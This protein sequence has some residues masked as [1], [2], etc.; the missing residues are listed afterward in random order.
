V[1]RTWE[2]SDCG[3]TG[4]QE[5]RGKLRTRCDGCRA[6]AGGSAPRKTAAKPARPQ[7][8]AP[9]DL[10]CSR[11]YATV[12]EAVEADLDALMTPHPM[13]EGLRALALELAGRV[14]DCEEKT[15]ASL[16]RELRATLDSLASYRTGG[17]DDTDGDIDLSAEVL[18]P[19][20]P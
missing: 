17:D 7:V 4:V 19:P 13:A 11:Q 12:A 6:G 18:D 3:A 5:G 14:H 8:A 15:L 9:S 16:A 20:F 10:G 2:C 1:A